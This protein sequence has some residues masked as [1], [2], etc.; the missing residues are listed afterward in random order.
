MRVDVK[1]YLFVGPSDYR[2][3]FFEDAQKEGIVEFIDSHKKFIQDVPEDLENMHRAHKILLGQQVRQQKE[4]ENGRTSLA[5][6]QEI[7][8]LKDDIDALYEKRRVT[9][10]EIARIEPFGDFDIEDVE[11]IQ[12][13]GKRKIQFFFTSKI[14]TITAPQNPEVFHIT[15]R[16]GLDY[17]IAINEKPRSYDGMIEMQIEKPLRLL[18]EQ[19]GDYTKEI[20]D[21]EKTLALYSQYRNV[22]DKA[23]IDKIN[24]NNL[25][26]SSEYV[27]YAM[28]DKIFAIEGWVAS[29]RIEK[30]EKFL[31]KKNV[32]CEEIEI[33]QTDR[34]P[35][36]LE[37]EGFARIGQDVINIYDAP[38]VTDKDPSKWVLWSFACFFAVINGDGGYGLVF[39]ALAL[40]LRYKFPKIKNA[41]KRMLNLFTILACS[42]IIWG[43]LIN[44]FFGIEIGINNP[45]RKFS[46]I[47]YLSEQKAE[48]TLQNKD[49]IYHEWVKKN[50]EISEA[51]NGFDF[52]DRAIVNGKHELLAT[53][54]DNIMLEISLMIGVIHIMISFLRSI[55][56]RW[57]GIGWIMFM[58]GGYLFFPSVL[59]ATSII[60]FAFGVDKIRGPELGIQLIWIGIGLAVIFAVIKDKLSGIKEILEVIQVFSDVLSYLRLYALALAGSMMSMTFNAMSQEM[61]LV[62]GIILIIIGHTVTITINVMGGVIHGL[63]LNFLEWYHYCFEGGGKLLK[64]LALLKR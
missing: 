19:C 62:L 30:L 14:E 43:L 40:F 56:K 22:I 50:P 10:M 13:E 38:A 60:H 44:S 21:K 15:H 23:L 18:C 64:P 16:H 63:R 11:F 27:K 46:L 32:H 9:T 42:C 48:Y 8:Q 61:N 34:V 59:G 51:N 7:T 31:N 29:N 24:E 25:Q 54:A 33:E 4:L 17:F 58:I 49:E 26:T 36:Y 53:F 20:N 37:N 1:K 5:L 41:G 55:L 57:S 2:D 52:L 3:D 12:K 45:L 35:T 47:Q 28:D 6:A 39:L